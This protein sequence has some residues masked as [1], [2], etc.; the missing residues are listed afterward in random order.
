MTEDRRWRWDET[1]LARQAAQFADMHRRLDAQSAWLKTAY[2]RL[3]RII[4]EERKER[5]RLLG[6]Y[7]SNDEP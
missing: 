2:A 1:H 6:H 4:A 7:E 3:D 5:T